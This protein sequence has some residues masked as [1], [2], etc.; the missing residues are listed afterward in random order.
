MAKLASKV[1]VTCSL[2]NPRTL[3][4]NTSQGHTR[5]LLA[6][7]RAGFPQDVLDLMSV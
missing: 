7:T 5:G 3:A 2:Q 6:R 4:Q 1:G